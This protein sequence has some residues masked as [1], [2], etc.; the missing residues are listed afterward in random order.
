MHVFVT[1]GTGTIG[2]AVVAELLG[3]GHTVLALARSDASAQALESAG[4]EALRGALADLDVLRSGA[5]QC[6]RRDQPGVRPRLQ[7]P[8]GARAV[9][10]RGERRP[11]RAGGGAH[12]QRPPDRHGLGHALGAGPRLH[13]GRPAADRRTGRRS[14]PL[15]H[16]AAGPGLARGAQHGR[17]HAAHGPQRGQGRIRRP[18]DRSRPPHRGGR[19]PG[20]RHPA[21]AGRARARRGRPVPAGPGVGTGRD[22][23]ARRRP[24]RATRCGTS[25]RSSAGGWACRSRRCRRRPSARSAR[26]SRWTSPP[27]APT[28]ATALGWQPTHPSLLE[29]LENIQ[30]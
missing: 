6:R 30:P 27:P 17:P 22:G 16:G 3:N 8:G 11:R 4:A 23:L 15:G 28:P 5:A 26:S 9:H 24:T 19:L 10:R 29:D 7:Q 21:L 25:P 12:R 20:R 1:G 14:G 13:R 18:A 2:S